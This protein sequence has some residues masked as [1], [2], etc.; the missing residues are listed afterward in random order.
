MRKRTKDDK[1]GPFYTLGQYKGTKKETPFLDVN[2]KI[3][4][5][6]KMG[7]LSRLVEKFN[8][9]YDGLVKL[10]IKREND[11]KKLE[12][13]TS[14]A[15]TRDHLRFIKKVLDGKTIRL[16]NTIKDSDYLDTTTL[17]IEDFKTKIEALFTSGKFLKDDKKLNFKVKIADIESKNDLN[18]R[19]IHDSEYYE[20]NEADDQYKKS[21][22]TVIQNVT[23]EGFS[24]DKNLKE[25]KKA[26]IPVV[27][28]DLIVKSDLPKANDTQGKISIFD[29]ES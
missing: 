7:V 14:D 22:D 11:W 28:N 25:A 9:E 21:G 27:I 2:P 26:A 23:L 12:I 20:S 10:V 8:K 18:I 24:E 3:Y 5:R 19:L 16:V 29:W 13:K 4:A 17:F 15:K 1:V 6:T